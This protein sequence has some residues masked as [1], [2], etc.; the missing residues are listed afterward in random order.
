[1]SRFS[2]KKWL[3]I[4]A[5]C[6]ALGLGVL[7]IFLPLLPTTVFLLI[8]AACFAR[9]SE[10]LY[11]WLLNHRWFGPIIRNWREHK[12]ISLRGKIF[13]LILLWLTLGCSAFCAVDLIAIRFLLLLVGL[14]VTFFILSTKTMSPDLLAEQK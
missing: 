5:G 3:L 13:M 9:S 6:L 7:G 8:A 10:R 12:A 11:Q 1:M 14:G 4:A 2:P